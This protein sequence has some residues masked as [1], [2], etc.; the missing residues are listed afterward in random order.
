M[1][2]RLTPAAP[3][4]MRKKLM[5]LLEQQFGIPKTTA[6]VTL[7]DWQKSRVLGAAPPVLPAKVV[8]PAYTAKFKK[9]VLKL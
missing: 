2:H 6:S 5:V 1:P 7:G 9:E 8:P 3:P 4:S